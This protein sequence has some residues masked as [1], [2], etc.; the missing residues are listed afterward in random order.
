M[1]VLVDKINKV[2]SYYLKRKLKAASSV[3]LVLFL[4][5]S[6]A[7]I[8]FGYEAHVVNVT[9]QICDYSEIK[10]M[11]YWKNHPNTYGHYLPQYLGVEL[12]DTG[13]KVNQVFLDYNL[14]M[15]NQLKGQLLA[16]KFNISRFGIGD[17]LVESEGKTLNQIVI[18]ADDLLSQTPQPPLETMKNL[19]AYLNNLGLIKHCATRVPNF[20][21]LII[22]KVYYDLGTNYGVEPANEWLEIYNP[23]DMPIDISGWKIQD[24]KGQDIISTSTP[25]PVP[26]FGFAL[27]T[28]ASTT[29]NYWSIP[30]GVIKIILSDGKIGGDGLD[31]DGDRIILKTPDGEEVDAMSYGGDT[32]AFDPSCP[33]VA[34]GHALGRVP[35]G[36]DTDKASDFK[37][38]G[39]PGVAILHPNS[40]ELIW[41]GR[42][43]TIQWTATNPNGNNN[44]LKIDLWYSG[45]NGFTWGKI[46]TGTENDGSYTWQVSL[47]L[48]DYYVPSWTARIK[49]VAV[50]PEN[51]MAQNWGISQQF[52]PPIDYDLITDEERQILIDMGLY[53]P[54]DETGSSTSLT[55]DNSTTSDNTATD[56]ES[57]IEDGLIYQGA[58]IEQVTSTEQATSTEEMVVNEQGTTTD[59]VTSTEEQA[60]TSLS[61]EQV[62]G[63][64]NG[65]AGDNNEG[66]INQE[67]TNNTEITNFQTTEPIIENPTIGELIEEAV[68][69][70]QSQSEQAETNAEE[71]NSEVINSEMVN[72]EVANTEGVGTEGERVNINNSEPAPATEPSNSS[73][74]YD[75]QTSGN[76]TV[77]EGSGISSDSSVGSDSVG[78]GSEATSEAGVGIASDAGPID[79]G[80]SIG[81]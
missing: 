7:Q 52:C 15:R 64:I 16:M 55:G 53:D 27:I 49:V 3:F 21:H 30:A 24:N 22:N 1:I 77:S 39:P 31:N 63:N 4:I 47:L 35:N 5:L 59:Q 71:N 80:E 45:D 44:D 37:D 54:P 29:F 36:F 40:S 65:L 33:D 81:E 61:G 66:I 57:V 32:Y 2:N 42:S 67:D 23:T 13:Q 69:E 20:E 62:V 78:A 56:T 18:Q 26:A 25:I 74:L 34:K 6:Q 51:F 76:E 9:A 43:F 8:L 72:L 10:S 41:V 46:A 38:L 48:G 60:P 11:N 50:G 12:I 58:A 79:S 14:S 17:Y 19:L 75:G 70:N 68:E 28:G 73:L